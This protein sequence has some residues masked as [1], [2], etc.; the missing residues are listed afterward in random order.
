MSSLNATKFKKTYSTIVSNNTER[1][2]SS[3][4]HTPLKTPMVKPRFA[5]FD[6]RISVLVSPIM[7]VFCG[8]TFNS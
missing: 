2:T 1:K 8:W 5:D 6:I 3:I 4:V 7:A